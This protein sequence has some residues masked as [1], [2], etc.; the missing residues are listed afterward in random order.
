APDAELTMEPPSSSNPD[1]ADASAGGCG[2]PPR[3]E[4]PNQAPPGLTREYRSDRI[5]V[6][7][8]AERCIHSA[9]CIRALPRVFDPR[10]RPW[11]QIDDAAADAVAEAV[12]R[13]PTGALHYVRHDGGP[14][15]PVPGDTTFRVV[16][17]GPLYVRG[18][19][20]VV[21]GEGEPVRRDTRVAL[22]RCGKSEHMPFCDNSHRAAGFRD[23][24]PARA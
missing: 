5:S 19:V 20:E 24:A 17:D 4:A 14:Q 2:A 15:E 13:C 7:W 21:T 22:C 11:V 16:R 23:P 9:E 18:P 12:L 3:P 8:F 6:L 1:Q 10:R